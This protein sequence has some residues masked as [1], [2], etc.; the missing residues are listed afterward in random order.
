MGI[1]LGKH[2]VRRL[3]TRAAHCNADIADG[4]GDRGGHGPRMNPGML[5][6]LD[7]NVAGR[8]RDALIGI[9]DVGLHVIS[10]L[11]VGQPDTDRERNAGATDRSCDRGSPREHINVRGV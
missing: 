5:G 2:D 7:R 11:V 4:R 6:G 1:G 8:A 10:D 9:G 3:G